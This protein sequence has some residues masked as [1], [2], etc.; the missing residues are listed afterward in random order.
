MPASVIMDL[1]MP[2]VAWFTCVNAGDVLDV[3][4]D[5][6]AIVAKHTSTETPS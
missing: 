2:L 5:M 4:A 6:D 3:L 1:L